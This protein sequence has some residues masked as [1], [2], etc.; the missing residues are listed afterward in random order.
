MPTFAATSSVDDADIEVGGTK[1]VGTDHVFRMGSVRIE[2]FSGMAEPLYELIKKGRMEEYRQAAFQRRST[3]HNTHGTG[4]G[5]PGSAT[6]EQVVAAQPPPLTAGEHY[7]SD[8]PF[9]SSV[10][11][12]T[13]RAETCSG[14]Q[15]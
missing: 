15:R 12:H 14:N 2:A 11:S 3:P 9:H 10:G 7:V 8:L 13:D 1:F 6:G 4:S 5:K